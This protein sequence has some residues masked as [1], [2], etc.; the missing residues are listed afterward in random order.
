MV[1][2][3]FCVRVEWLGLELCVYESIERGCLGVCDAL[4]DF[5]D[6]GC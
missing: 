6:L 4:V 3:C 1:Q 2:G 5:G